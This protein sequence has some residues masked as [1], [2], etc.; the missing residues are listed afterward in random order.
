MYERRVGIID[1]CFLVKEYTGYL[2]YGEI[3]YNELQ[4]QC[5]GATSVVCD[6]DIMSMRYSP[7]Q[8]LPRL[9]AALYGHAL[10]MGISP[11][12]L[13]L[14]D[15]VCASLLPSLSNYELL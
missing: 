3:P 7:M 6:Y 11:T 4:V 15:K 5:I 8:P 2:E 9:L 13:G 14:I 1:K 12:R 10:E